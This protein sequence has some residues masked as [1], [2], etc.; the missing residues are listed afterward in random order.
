MEL[1]GALE[2][3]PAPGVAL[4]VAEAKDADVESAPS[5]EAKD[6]DVESAPSVEAPDVDEDSAPSAEAKDADV[7]GSPSAE[8][9]DADEDS[10]P[11]AKA[12]DA[13]ED[14]AEAPDADE[15]SAPSPEAQGAPAEEA[16]EAAGPAISQPVTAD[17]AAAE[18]IAD[19]VTVVVEDT[20]TEQPDPGRNVRKRRRAILE[21][22]SAGEDGSSGEDVAAPGLLRMPPPCVVDG[23]ANLMDAGADKCTYLNSDED[24]SVEEDREDQ[25]SSDD[26]DEDDWDI[27]E[28]TDEESDEGGD[29]LPES[30]CNSVA[31]RKKAIAMMRMHGW[32]YDPEQFGPDPRY[33]NLFDGS[34]GPSESVM[35]ASA[36]ITAFFWHKCLSVQTGED[37]G[38]WSRIHIKYLHSSAELQHF[39]CSLHVVDKETSVLLVEGFERFFTDHSH[40]GSVYQT[41][42]F[43]VE[44]QEHMRAATGSGVAV[45]TG[46]TNAFL[47]QD[48]PLLRRWCRFLEIVPDAEEPD[49][50]TLR[51]EV[52]NAVGISEDVARVQVRYE[53]SPPSSQDDTGVFQ[54][55]H[56]QRRSG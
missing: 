24:M 54:L 12:P 17:L 18:V 43:L 2:A 34:Y 8:A 4:S 20:A 28:L 5:A 22:V 40:M 16:P 25:E 19:M 56:V 30:V 29:D 3:A 55:Q 26:G 27:G 1:R 21:D 15:D 14:S 36:Y 9:P 50:Y 49:V 51:E 35:T 53:F 47:L 11:S 32:E 42:A 13:D 38:I 6:A 23:D 46:N 10:A 48:R 37:N 45:V 31:Q 44:A 33:E 39:L 52:E 41:L 7:E